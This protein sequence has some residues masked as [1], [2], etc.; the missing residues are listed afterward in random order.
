MRSE[1]TKLTD[2]YRSH[3]YKVRFKKQDYKAR[4]IYKI[5]SED[6]EYREIAEE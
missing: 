5:V 1:A 6:P 4:E 2:N 3:A